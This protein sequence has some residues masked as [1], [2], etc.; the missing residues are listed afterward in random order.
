LEVALDL[1]GLRAFKAGLPQ[2]ISEGAEI[3][4]NFVGD[5]AQQLAPVD[6]GDLRDSK[7]VKPGSNPGTWIV[8]F[9]EGLPDPRAVVQEYGSEDMP[10]QPYLGPA[11]KDVDVKKEI[12]AKI[13]ALAR[14][15]R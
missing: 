2:A 15:S 8:S 9:G 3:A 11:V 10:A 1:S 4:A 14:R 6:E 12:K 13:E 7:Q 5:L